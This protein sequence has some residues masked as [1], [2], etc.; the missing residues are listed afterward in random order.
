MHGVT[1]GLKFI[2][3]NI[4]REGKRNGQREEEKEGP[5]KGGREGISHPS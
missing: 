1:Y 4:D 3:S 5:R 2:L